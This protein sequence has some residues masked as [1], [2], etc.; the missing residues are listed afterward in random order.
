[1]FQRYGRW[2]REEGS[3][4]KEDGRGKMGEGR[5]RRGPIEQMPAVVVNDA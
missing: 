1:M 5:R 4:E 3:G 2:E